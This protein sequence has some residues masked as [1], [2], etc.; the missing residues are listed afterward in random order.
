MSACAKPTAATSP[1]FFLIVTITFNSEYFPPLP[2]KK[3]SLGWGDLAQFVKCL[4]YGWEFDLQ[5]L[6]KVMS[7]MGKGRWEIP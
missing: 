6:Y 3:S 2:I 5:N 4:H 7:S 1:L